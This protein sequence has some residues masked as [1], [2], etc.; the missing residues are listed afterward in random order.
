MNNEK[1]CIFCKIVAE[2]APA[3][4]IWQD[5]AHIAFLS[6]FPNTEGVTVVVSREHLT[7]DIANLSNEDYQAI[8]NA[9]KTVANLL[10]DAF[11]DVARTGIVAEGFGVDH[12]HTKLFP[13]HGTA[14]MDEWREHPSQIDTYFEEYPGYLSSHDSKQVGRDELA[15][16]AEKIRQAR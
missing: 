6:I 8:M 3:E 1:D 9:T 5:D 7:S 13:M 2:D 12:A 15:R 16:V 10:T 11:N 4:I 14:P